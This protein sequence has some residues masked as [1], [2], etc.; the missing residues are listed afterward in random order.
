MGLLGRPRRFALAVTGIACAILL[1]GCAECRWPRIDPSGERV[2]VLAPEPE[3][4]RYRELPA[5]QLPWDPVEVILTPRAIAAPVGSEVV[6]LAGVRGPDNYLRTNERVQWAISAGSVGQFVEIDKGTYWDLVVGDFT[7]PRIISP[8]SAVGTTSR[9]HVRLTRGTPT[10]GDDVLVASGQTWITVTSPMEGSTYVTAY[11]REVYGWDRHKQSAVIHWI[12]AQWRFPPPAIVAPG[13]R[14]VLTTTVTRQSDQSPAIGWRVR[15]TICG[16]PPAGFVPA[17]AQTA[18]VETNASGQASVEIVQRE[19]AAGT[20]RVDIQVSRPVQAGAPAGTLTVLGSG[21]TMVTWSAPGMGPTAPWAPGIPPTVPPA[22]AVP[23]FVSPGVPGARPGLE[24]KIAGPERAT[25]GEKVQFNITL[26]NRG[27][28]TATGLSITDTFDRGLVNEL[29]P[30]RNMIVR[31]LP[32]DLAPNEALELRVDFVVSKAGRLCHNVEVTGAGGLRAMSQSCV[33]AVEGGAKVP[34]GPFGPAAPPPSA[35][36][37]RLTVK[38]IAKPGTAEVGD[39]AARIETAT[40]G[41]LVLLEIDVTN[42]G[43]QPLTSATL[44]ATLDPALKPENATTGFRKEPSA[45]S[46]TLATLAPG[47]Q[48]QF[49]IQCR[50]LQPIAGAYVRAHVTSQ[51]GVQ[52]EDSLWLPIRAAGPGTPNTSGM[53]GA[54]GQPGF[55]ALRVSIKTLYEPIAVDRML[56]YTVRV[57]NTSATA[58][59]RDVAVS[60]EVPPEMIPSAFGTT[61]PTAF[62]FKGQVV[63]F[64]PK[65]RVLPG[66]GLEYR[67]RVQAKRAGNVRVQAR[68][69]SQSLRE[70]QVA[71]TRTTILEG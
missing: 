52:G 17:G 31:P 41:Q 67:V 21:S 2:F 3:N 18:E 16:G 4:P 33:T 58:E 63:T 51:Q 19:P 12:D 15:Y 29:A 23:P 39:S 69:T 34:S 53:P 9:R 44:T 62:T 5:G 43:L 45:L 48:Y 11:A 54:E 24:V 57:D 46:W 70:P 8:T 10:P 37:G 25:V 7:W 22:A 6:L 35:A 28:T 61:G 68:V 32:Y 50:C 60:V 1:A 59:E 27:Q 20:N 55:S 47:E 14:Q 71:E 65:A 38:M 64:E 40:V 66:E 42:R 56:T 13:G 30:G 36:T 26:I 49:G